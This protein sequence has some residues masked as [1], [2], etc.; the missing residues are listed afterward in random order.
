M[1]FCAWWKRALC[2]SFA[3]GD[4]IPH[5]GTAACPLPR[6][7]GAVRQES[8]GFELTIFAP[9]AFKKPGNPDGLPGFFLAAVHIK[10]PGRPLAAKS[11]AAIALRTGRL[12]KSSAGTFSAKGNPLRWGCGKKRPVFCT[13]SP[14]C[15][16]PG[17]FG[18]R[19]TP[20]A[21]LR[22]TMGQRR[23]AA[24]LQMILLKP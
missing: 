9:G 11:A 10:L 24:C 19:V 8:T 17:H 3:A 16:R 12:L 6:V 5:S 20:C 4:V 1:R 13:V 18:A 23:H 22:H 7:L 15:R 14:F 21:G 2:H